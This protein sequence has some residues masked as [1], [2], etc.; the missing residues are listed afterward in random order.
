MKFCTPSRRPLPTSFNQRKSIARQA[1][2]SYAYKKIKWCSWICLGKCSK[3]RKCPGSTR[4]SIICE[5]DFGKHTLFLG[6]SFLAQKVV[7][8]AG[9]RND[10]PERTRQL[11]KGETKRQR[12]GIPMFMGEVN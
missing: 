12:L 6:S 3:P 11:F 5:R 7:Q 8:H 4:P 10:A 2:S 1:L 9:T